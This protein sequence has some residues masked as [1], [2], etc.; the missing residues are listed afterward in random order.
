M[1]WMENTFF[2]HLDRFSNSL[3]YDNFGIAFSLAMVPWESP[4]DRDTFIRSITGVDPKGG[5]PST[6]NNGLAVM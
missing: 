1:Q 2:D 5:E 3:G 4:D 6:F